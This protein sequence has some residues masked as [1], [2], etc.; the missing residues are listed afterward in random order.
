MSHWTKIKLQLTNKDIL[1]K[2]LQRMGLEPQVGKFNI[3]QYGQSEESEI[4]VGGSVGFN[5]QKDGTFSMV[6]DFYHA[7]GS[8][9]KYY[10][11]NQQF[12]QD[13]NV[14]YG[15]EDAKQ[16][17]EDLGMGFEIEENEQGIIG[18]DGMIRM[19]AVS[20]S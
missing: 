4:K 10:G 20:Y 1:V 13:L 9:K 7:S 12:Q 18:K 14:A 19:V 11:K 6:G 3:S 16:K 15:I 2:A 17:L 8:V 5:R